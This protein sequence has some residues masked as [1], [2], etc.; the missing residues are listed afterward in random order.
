MTL[1][2]LRQLK[3]NIEKKSLSVIK[4]FT[5]DKNSFNI[6]KENF[7][8]FKMAIHLELST[9]QVNDKY[10]FDYYVKRKDNST[11][12]E[13]IIIINLINCYELVYKYELPFII[14]IV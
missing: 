7:E 12:T 14:K 4:E 3:H 10:D 1:E 13:Y 6:S 8:K 9:L 2:E 11:L 5:T